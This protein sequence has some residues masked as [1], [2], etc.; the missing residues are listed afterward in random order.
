MAANIKI[1]RI[2]VEHV[3]LTWIGIGD[4]SQSGDAAAIL[5]QRHNAART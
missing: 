1:K 2:G 5:F 3:Q 4:L